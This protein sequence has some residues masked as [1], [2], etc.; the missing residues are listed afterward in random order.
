MRFKVAGFQFVVIAAALLFGLG[1]TAVAKTIQLVGFGDSLMAGYQLPPG[2]GFPA[3][4]EAA[5][6]A[7]GL[8]VAISDA[9]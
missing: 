6:K 1:G 3:K 9:G 4:L 8:D 7:K 5:L 2:N